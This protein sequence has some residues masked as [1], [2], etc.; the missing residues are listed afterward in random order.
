MKHFVRGTFK[1]TLISSSLVL[2]AFV[3]TPLVTKAAH[4]AVDSVQE[5]GKKSY[6][7][8]L[9]TEDG[10]VWFSV[11]YANPA[12][13]KFTLIVKNEEGDVLYEGSFNNQQFSKKIK[14]VLDEQ[15]AFPTFVIKTASQQYA[16]TFQV[17]ADTRM[18]EHVVVTKL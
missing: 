18:V 13:E 11:N 6:V 8:Y 7:K 4:N 5:N 14:L 1:K 2:G 10:D 12:G 9:G 3:V 15:D 16:Q 17:S